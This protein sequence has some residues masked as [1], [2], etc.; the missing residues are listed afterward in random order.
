MNRKIIFLDIDGTL[1]AM[2]HME[3][4]A[5]AVTAIRRAQQN[6]HLVYLCTGR[7]YAML[8][9]VLRYGFD[10]VV[11]NAGGYI[12]CGGEAIFDCPMEAELRERTVRILGEYGVLCMLEAQDA[13]F[14]DEGANDFMLRQ[15]E[16]GGSSELRRWQ[17][18]MEKELNI[19]PVEE[20]RGEPVYK[21]VVVCEDEKQLMRAYEQLKEDFLLCLQDFEKNGFANGELINRRFNKGLAMERVC[22]HLGIPLEDSFAFGDSMNDKEMI[23]TAGVGL[24]MADGNKQLRAVADDICPPAQEDGLYR[25]FEKYGLI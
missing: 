9:P 23:E 25:M 5:S 21:M 10:G 14:A 19:H 15:A 16:K 20:Y 11:A 17:E 4:P 13:V 2:G 22:A 8:S 1:I 18:A 24:C 7:N 3:P 12:L 6:G